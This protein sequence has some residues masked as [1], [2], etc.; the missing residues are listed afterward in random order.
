MDEKLKKLR[1]LAST[2][3]KRFLE[4]LRDL[5][6]EWKTLKKGEKKK[7]ENDIRTLEKVGNDLFLNLY[8]KR[9]DSNEN[10]ISAIE[11]GSKNVF[12]KGT[13]Q[14]NTLKLREM[15]SLIQDDK[16]EKAL[17]VMDGI[18][19][20]VKSRGETILNTLLI[21]NNR[22]NVV[23]KAIKNGVS[24]FRYDGPAG[25]LVREFC[26]L[27]VGKEFTIEEIKLMD[28]G[29]RLPVL[30]FCGG[31]NCRH[32]WVA[33]IVDKEKVKPKDDYYD[34]EEDYYDDQYIDIIGD[35]FDEYYAREF[36]GVNKVLPDAIVDYFYDDYYGRVEMVIKHP[37][38][39]VGVRY[40]NY[41]YDEETLENYHLRLQPEYRG[42]GIAAQLLYEQL[43]VCRNYGIRTIK[44]H[45]VTNEHDYNGHYTW[46]RYG[47]D[48]DLTYLEKR[49]LPKFLKDC[50]T[51]Q[52]IMETAK[53]RLWWLNHGWNFY[54]E[55]DVD[56]NS[57][58]SII[59]ENYMNK[60]GLK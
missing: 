20:N 18:S 51:L 28:N 29:Q 19:S 8:S 10:V 15:L 58:S 56:E 21:G 49:K 31:Y 24:K 53:G 32:R 36:T 52:D 34:D 38:L 16:T 55:F 23:E 45:A 26:R 60:R 47:Y 48:F 54:G 2:N 46:A 41:Q 6:Q 5:I 50:E 25:P 7:F 9:A 37:A 44:V 3:S 43:L 11:K 14:L 27:R 59:L 22:A 40:L 30:Q 35:R 17:K 13:L 42:Q 33:V 57:R 12:D 1:L 4:E 39:Q